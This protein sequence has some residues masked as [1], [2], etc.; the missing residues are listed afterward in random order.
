LSHRLHR[1]GYYATTREVT[2]E[3]DTIAE[4]TVNLQKEVSNLPFHPYSDLSRVLKGMEEKSH[5]LA[6]MLR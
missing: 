6:K 5:G 4:L 1:S 3:Q 2:V